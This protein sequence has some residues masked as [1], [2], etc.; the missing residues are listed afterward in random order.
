MRLPRPLS[1]RPFV[2]PTLLCG[3]VLITIKILLMSRGFGGTLKLVRRLHQPNDAPQPA[4]ISA[5]KT[6]ARRVAAVSA[7]Y[8]GRARCLEQALTLYS[9]LLI[10]H[11]PA[12]LCFGVRAYGFSAH[13]WVEWSGEPIEERPDRIRKLMPLRHL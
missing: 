10:A 8:P 3:G 6:I 7:Y 9:C 13:A 1:K 11:I 5:V 12:Q 4:Q 2:P